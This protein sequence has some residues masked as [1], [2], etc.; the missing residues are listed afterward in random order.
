MNMRFTDKRVVIGLALLALAGASELALAQGA[1]SPADA[2]QYRQQHLKQLGGAFK[3]V[4]DEVRGGSPNLDTVKTN[5]A[6]MQKLA[7]EFPTWF[8]A[9]SGPEAGVPTQAKAEIW[10]N[11]ATFDE[12]IKALQTAVDGLAAAGDA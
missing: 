4:T 9:G 1:K 5:A 11:R 7:A 12:K 6:A 2:I 10:A 8:P 3:A